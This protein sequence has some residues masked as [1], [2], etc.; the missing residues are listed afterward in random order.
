[1][2]WLK[3]LWWIGRSASFY[4]ELSEALPDTYKEF[5]AK[6]TVGN[7]WRKLKNY[8][9]MRDVLDMEYMD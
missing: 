3:N 5:Y 1:M 6:Y 9:D 2:T 7:G 4:A 8:Y